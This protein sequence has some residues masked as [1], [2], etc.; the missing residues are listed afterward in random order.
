MKSEK[1]YQLV[2]KVLEWVEANL[3]RLAIAFINTKL[4]QGFLTKIV[5]WFVG[6]AFDKTITPIFQS[7]AVNIGYRF[8]VRE[9]HILLLK[10][11]TASEANDEQAY[12][13]AVDDLLGRL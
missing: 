1:R 13:D 6:K 9:G 11:K 10:I 5:S 3:E 4:G 12:N 2:K 7:I 8:D